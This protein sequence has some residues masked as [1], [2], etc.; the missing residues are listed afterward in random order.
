MKQVAILIRIILAVGTCPE[1]IGQVKPLKPVPLEKAPREDRPSEPPSEEEFTF[2]ILVPQLIG[3]E[4][5]IRQSFRYPREAREQGIKGEVV[6]S[7]V[8]NEEGG[9]EDVVV[10]QSIGGGCDEE[11]MRVVREARFTPGREMR[12]SST[13]NQSRLGCLYRSD[14]DR[15]CS[16]VCLIRR[17]KDI[18]LL[19]LS[20]RLRLQRRGSV[21][22]GRT[23]QSAQ[24]RPA[25]TE[26]PK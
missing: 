1:V 17:V 10:D 3:G 7:F 15:P 21:G 2:V 6:V 24:L 12:P 20:K 14:A 19:P 22:Y 4:E 5:S 8:V 16:G 13:E 23:S 9:V 25:R 18:R 26:S 11:A